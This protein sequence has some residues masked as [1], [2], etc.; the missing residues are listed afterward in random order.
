MNYL[1]YRLLDTQVFFSQMESECF[2]E[3]CILKD[4]GARVLSISHSAAL[5]H[6]GKAYGGI[7]SLWGFSW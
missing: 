4:I 2:R 6:G 7:L 1:L 5:D 3:K